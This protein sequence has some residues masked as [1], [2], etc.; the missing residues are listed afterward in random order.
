M[1]AFD[2]IELDHDGIAE[3]LHSAEVHDALHTVAEQVAETARAGGH[4]VT[5][6]AELPI[7]VFDDPNRDRTAV[8]VAIRHP[9]GVGMEARYGVLK[10]AA[11]TAGLDVAGL[12]RE[13]VS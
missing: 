11:E 10:R 13:D 6:G 4:R 3:L 1:P 9:A 5:S 7:E 12:N 2:R 8:T